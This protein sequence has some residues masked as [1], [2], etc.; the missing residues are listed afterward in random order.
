VQVSIRAGEV[1]QEAKVVFSG[2]L[3]VD[4]GRLWV[5]DMTRFQGVT[6]DC[7]SGSLSLKI[8][9]A[10]PPWASRVDLVFNFGSGLG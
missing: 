1:A 10:D 6:I 4:S 7:P 3:Q 9:V 8:A 2:N 5:G